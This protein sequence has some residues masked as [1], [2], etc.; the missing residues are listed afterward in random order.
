[1]FGAP[2]K[3]ASRPIVTVHLQRRSDE[4][5]DG[6]LTGK[7]AENTIRAETSVR[8][9]KKYIWPSTYVFVHS[10]SAAE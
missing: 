9:R 6:I 3:P 7:L 2:P 1:M 8:A 5:I 4:G 10:H